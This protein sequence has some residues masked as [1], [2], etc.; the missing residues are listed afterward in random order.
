MKRIFLIGYM[1]S[2]KTSIGKLLATRLNYTF[3][4]IDTYI[5]NKYHKTVPQIFADH[6]EAEFR[7]MEQN[8]LHEVAEFE[9]AVISTGGGSPC[10]FNN[11][12]YMSTHGLTVYLKLTPAQ[13]AER[14]EH[15]RPNKR[16]LLAE[17]KGEELLRFI[18]DGLATREPFYDKA[19]LSVN[20]TDE[21]IIEKIGNFISRL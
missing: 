4:D 17:R 3:V 11:M 9:G 19:T 16:P 8:C 14:L 20:G 13:L 15:S 12:E 7:Q 2:G 21:D 10:F 6:G 18:T 5:E 1:G